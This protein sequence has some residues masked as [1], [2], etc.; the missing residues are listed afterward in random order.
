M[1]T[2]FEVDID[3][4]SKLSLPSKYT[5]KRYPSAKLLIF[6]ELPNW[7]V[8]DNIEFIILQ[9]LFKYPIKHSLDTYSNDSV[10]NTIRKLFSRNIVH[11][12]NGQGIIN[13]Y[14][15]PPLFLYITNSCNLRCKHCYMYS[16]NAYSNELSLDQWKEIIKSYI[17]N[18]GKEIIFCGGEPLILKYFAELIKCTKEY[19]FDIK[20][21]VFTN[22]SFINNYPINF[23]NKYV[24]ELQISIDG[25]FEEL[26]D[27]IR[28]KGH[29][30]IIMKNVKYLNSYSGLVT[31]S[32]SLYNESRLDIFTKNFEQFFKYINKNILNLRFNIIT[33]LL[34][35]R[36]FSKL[37]FEEAD[38]KT[39][40]FL[41]LL[42]ENFS[43]GIDFIDDTKITRNY[44]KINCGYGGTLTISADGQVFPCGWT[45]KKSFGL[46]QEQTIS[47]WISGLNTV[48]ET[49]SVNN[50]SY[51]Y[52]CDLKY[53]CGGTCRIDNCNE[54]NDILKP[55]C[56]NSYKQEMY[57]SLFRNDTSFENNIILEGGEDNSEK[58]KDHN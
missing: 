21:R 11:S 1:K 2:S 8:L 27:E 38:R 37:G 57:H 34:Q 46:Y 33:E 54:N 4:N 31:I 42:K 29:F 41:N 18:K 36:C 16:G 35:G 30:R 32:M 5:I 51:C 56:T 47:D 50:M 52:S 39:K 3:I 45:S 14:F 48:F 53:I 44:K 24:D 49:Y 23:F 13:E 15:P 7:I 26:H 58:Q 22:G 55:T 40:L 43:H 25:P 19:S 10:I 6:Y 17:D 12:N 28:G 9:D 20:I